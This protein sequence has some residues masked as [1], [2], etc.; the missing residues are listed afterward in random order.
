[1]LLQF[2]ESWFGFLNAVQKVLNAVR[3]RRLQKQGKKDQ[4]WAPFFERR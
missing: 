4:S 1:M 3:K 2:F